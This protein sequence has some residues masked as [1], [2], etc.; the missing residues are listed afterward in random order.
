MIRNICRKNH[1]QNENDWRQFSPK[2]LFF[3]QVTAHPPLLFHPSR[4]RCET[5]THLG[6][7][8]LRSRQQTGSSE[9]QGPILISSKEYFA[10][11]LL[12]MTDPTKWG[13]FHHGELLNSSDHP[14]VCLK[15][16]S[17]K[18]FTQVQLLFHGPAKVSLHEPGVNDSFGHSFP[19]RIY[20]T[21][22]NEI[23]RRLVISES[24]EWRMLEHPNL[25]Q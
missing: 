13:H 6:S 15:A 22:S 25:L 10:V 17:Q 3:R 20:F 7:R 16:T 11:S 1:M 18:V 23:Y 8:V 2:T 19:F 21:G 14:D 12:F 9:V 5:P 24:R 4:W